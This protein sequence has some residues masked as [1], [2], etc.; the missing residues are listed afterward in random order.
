M[1]EVLRTSTDQRFHNGTIVMDKALYR[2]RQSALFC[3]KRQDSKR[4]GTLKKSDCLLVVHM[5]YRRH[6]DQTL[7]SKYHVIYETENCI[8]QLIDGASMSPFMRHSST[9]D[10]EYV[11]VCRIIAIFGDTQI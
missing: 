9:K 11:I 7:F 5:K 4:R 2:R 10:E 1:I 6:G 8:F 3:K